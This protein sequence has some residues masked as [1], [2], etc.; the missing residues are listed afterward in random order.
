MEFNKNEKNCIDPGLKGAFHQEAAQQ[1]FGGEIDV[2][3]ASPFR[4]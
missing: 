2:C 4:G 3:S 1:Y